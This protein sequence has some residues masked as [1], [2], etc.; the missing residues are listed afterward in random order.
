MESLKTVA[1]QKRK[2]LEEIN[3]KLKHA[4]TQISGLFKR[5]VSRIIGLKKHLRTLTA[6]AE[7]LA[8]LG[9]KRDE[10]TDTL[11][12]TVKRC[13][14]TRVKLLNGIEEPR[15]EVKHHF[16]IFSLEHW[17]GNPQPNILEVAEALP[18]RL[19]L[20]SLAKVN[21]LSTED[22]WLRFRILNNER[23]ALR[24]KLSS[25]EEH[26]GLTK[27]HLVDYQRML[28]IMKKSMSKQQLG[29]LECNLKDAMAPA[30]DE[31]PK[32]LPKRTGSDIRSRFMA[33][34]GVGKK[35][36]PRRRIDD[37]DAIISKVDTTLGLKDPSRFDNKQIG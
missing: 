31:T 3:S 37:V 28:E 21:V 25:V 34:L 7:D 10:T 2:D 8:L 4:Q 27:G 36:Q 13:D 24:A 11:M 19:L 20:V 26:R 35:S 32:M 18:G 9:R 30:V 29:K 5:T 17:R 12:R 33:G 14:D 15:W 16:H 22:C 23:D 1:T 6:F